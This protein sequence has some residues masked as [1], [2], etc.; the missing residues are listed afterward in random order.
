M[1][2]HQRTGE[3]FESETPALSTDQPE[4]LE[5][6][7]H[8]FKALALPSL[9]LG[10]SAPVSQEQDV[11]ASAAETLMRTRPPALRSA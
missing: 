10:A 4:G 6:D 7:V 5:P 8:G 11:T 1:G 3:G 9:C 2:S